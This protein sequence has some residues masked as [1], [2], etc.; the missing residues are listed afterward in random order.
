MEESAK[1][2]LS[3]YESAN[4]M[5]VNQ[6]TTAKDAMATNLQMMKLALPSSFLMLPMMFGMVN[7]LISDF[8]LKRIGYEVKSFKALGQWEMPASLKYFLMMLLLGDFIISIFQVTAI[9]QIYIVTVMNFV[10]IIFYIMGLSLI[11]NYMEY[12][13]VNSKGLKVLV[14][15]LSFII[16]SIITLV[17]VADTYIGIRRIYRRESQIK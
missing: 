3:F 10:N 7:V 1:E 12:K 15:F 9:S 4:I 5:N 13:D 8:I 14:V 17:G 2:V 11:F 6:L 16:I